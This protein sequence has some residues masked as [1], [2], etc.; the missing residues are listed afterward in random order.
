MRVVRGGEGVQVMGLG[1]KDYGCIR[2]GD[3]AGGWGGET[4]WAMGGGERAWRVEVRSCWWVRWPRAV[5]WRGGSSG[6]KVGAY[7]SR[8]VCARTLEWVSLERGST[9]VCSPERG[10]TE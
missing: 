5:E 9:G 6:M 2:E 8:V 7:G 3:H 4:R 1:W 10:R